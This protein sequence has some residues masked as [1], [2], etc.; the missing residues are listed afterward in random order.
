MLTTYKAGGDIDPAD[1][2]LNPASVLLG[3]KVCETNSELAQKFMS[4]MVDQNGGQAVV[5]SFKP[6][7]TNDFLYT[8]APDC[9]TQPKF[10]D[11]W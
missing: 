8:T 2:L 5:K 10:C 7:G 6:P 4:W 11:G 9:V 1:P 3:A